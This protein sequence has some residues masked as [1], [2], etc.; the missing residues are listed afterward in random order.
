MRIRAYKSVRLPLY[1]GGVGGYKHQQ[2]AGDNLQWRTAKELD[3]LAVGAIR[4]FQLRAAGAQG[5]GG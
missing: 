2:E 4:Q 5:A 1:Y 3:G